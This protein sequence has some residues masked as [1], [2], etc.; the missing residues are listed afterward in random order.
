MGKLTIEREKIGEKN[1][2]EWVR[3]GETKCN[4]SE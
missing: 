3:I 1:E 4:V 2:R